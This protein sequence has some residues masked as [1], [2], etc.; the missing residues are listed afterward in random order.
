MC[1]HLHYQVVVCV[2]LQ[3]HVLS[4]SLP[5]NCCLCV[6][7]VICV[8]TFITK[9]FL[10]VCVYTL[11]LHVLSPSLPSHCYLCVFTVT[12]VV[13]FITKSLLLVCVYSYMCCHLH[14]QVI[15]TCVC[16]QLHVLLPSL[17][18]L[19]YLCVFT[20]TC[21]VTFIIKSLLLVCVLQ[22]HVLS[23]SLSS[24]SYLCV[25]TVTC[26]V[27]FITKSLLLVCVYSYMCCHLHYQ[28]IATCV[29]L[30]L[31]VSS[32]SLSSHSYLRVF[33]VT[34]VV[35]FIIKSLLLVCVYSYMCCHLHYQVI[36]TCVC[37]Q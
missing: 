29:C 27:T 2:Y 4:P 8:V 21:V 20:V 25:F 15:A 28:V 11:Q 7:T 13:T 1:C 14:Y 12:C 17:S 9:S 37:L 24:H 26:V 16:L 10:L 31:H 18:S 22:L 32:P 35:T 6:F 23:P 19:C 34:C 30:Q 5:S 33:T 36:A 3:L